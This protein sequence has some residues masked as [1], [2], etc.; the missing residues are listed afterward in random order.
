M[1]TD[2]LIGV[3]AAAAGFGIA[4]LEHGASSAC[5][6][7][8]AADRFEVMVADE[9]PWLELCMSQKTLPDSSVSRSID[10]LPGTS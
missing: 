7:S 1:V 10:I 8:S 5:M 2:E 4:R 6:S 3:F 9:L